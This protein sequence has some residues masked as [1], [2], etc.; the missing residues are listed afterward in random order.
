MAVDVTLGPRFEAGLPKTLFET[1][2]LTASDFRNHYV[3]TA[4]GQRFLINSLPEEKGATA[5]DI[6]KN[7]PALTQR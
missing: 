5:I 7:W 3:V 4:D 6:V 1:R 2:A